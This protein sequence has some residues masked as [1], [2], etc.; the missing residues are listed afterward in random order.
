MVSAERPSAALQE[1]LQLFAQ[2]RAGEAEVVV[3]KAAMAAKAKHGSGSHPLARAYADIARLHVRMGQFQK[4]AVEFQ[5]AS[6]GP[7]PAE[8][9]ARGDRLGF[10]FGYAE[11]LVGLTRYD[12]AEKV[13][14]QCV[15]FARSLYGVTSAAANAANVP[16]A[17]VLLKA[18]KTVEAMKLAQDSY[19]ALWALGDPLITA[20]IPVR[21]EALKA[22]GRPDSPFTDLAD[23][24]DELVSKTVAAVIARAPVGDPGRMRAVLAE[25]LAFADKKCGDGHAV[26][27]DVLAAIAHHETRQGTGADASVRRTA[28]RRSVWSYAVRR[29]PAGLLANL[30]VAFEPDGALH[31]VPHLARE[32]NVAETAQLQAILTQA[33]DDLYSRPG[34]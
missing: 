3:K 10:M 14:R 5:H 25:L 31:L 9:A 21:A 8:A 6:K 26:T 13:L 7:M 32:A 17:D 1:A 11:A 2:G 34:A 28:V 18:G 12:E 33:V 4:A 22:A 29:A 20:V 24:P 27:C 19:N 30:E 16:L 23:L 15:T